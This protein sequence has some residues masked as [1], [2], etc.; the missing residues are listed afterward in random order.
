[1]YGIYLEFV[2]RFTHLVLCTLLLPKQ[3]GRRPNSSR[4]QLLHL[5]LNHQQ[6]MFVACLGIGMRALHT[7]ANRW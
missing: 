3:A 7:L 2:G 1:M 4:S 5:F 6:T